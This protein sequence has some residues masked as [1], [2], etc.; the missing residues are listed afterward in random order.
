MHDACAPHGLYSSQRLGALHSSL[1]RAFP[2]H[3]IR[4]E[5]WT[6]GIDFWADLL[7]ID[8][9]ECGVLRSPRHELLETSYEGVVDFG[10]VLAAEGEALKLM[11]RAGVPVPDVVKVHRATVADEPSWMLQQRIHH[12]ETAEIPLRQLGQLT[13]LIHGI[14]PAGD[15]LK[16]PAEWAAAFWRRLEQRLQAAA[17]YCQGL[18]IDGIAGALPWLEKRAAASTSL[19]HMDLRTTNIC[20]QDTKIVA[21]IDAANCIVGDPL[22]ELGR[23]R[24]YGYLGDEFMAGYGG[25]TWTQAELNLLDVYELDTAA[26]LT[27]VGIEEVNDPD[28]HAFQRHRVMQLQEQIMC[29]LAGRSETR[30]PSNHGSPPQRP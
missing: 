18:N 1:V 13:R 5:T 6:A 15:L 10:A 26:L 22:L 2:G 24:A 30:H 14:H 21:I 3:D 28:L 8:G 20:V 16:P 19:L 17:P 4:V 9:G 23:I 27:V 7:I 11:G 25:P 29:A 12:D